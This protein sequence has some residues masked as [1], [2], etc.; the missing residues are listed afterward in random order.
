MAHSHT[1][2]THS[3][4]FICTF[5]EKK[6]SVARCSYLVNLGEG[7]M[8]FIVLFFYLFYG[9]EIFQNEKLLGGNNTVYGKPDLRTADRQ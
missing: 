9:F 4:V 8:V 5:G 6:A 1:Q 7:Y 2:C 3:N